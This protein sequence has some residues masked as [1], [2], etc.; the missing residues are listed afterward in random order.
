[1]NARGLGHKHAWRKRVNTSRRNL[2]ALAAG[3]T[4]ISTRTQAQRATQA[5]PQP[6]RANV[7]NES[8]GG[9]RERKNKFTVGLAS[10]QIEG[11]YPRF[12]AEL[13]KVLD[14]GDNLRVLPYLAYGAA[15]NVEDLLYLRGVDIAF[16]Q[17]DVL[18]YYRTQLKVPNLQDRIGYILRLYNT[19][20]HIL[21]ASD[22]RTMEDLR[23]RKVSFG[24]AGNSA[25]LTGPVVFQRLG[26]P[27]EQMLL[28]HSMGLDRLR[29]GEISAVVRVV[30]KP[31]DYFS[32]I[33]ANSGLHFLAIPGKKVFDDIYA[34]AEL[35]NADYP[36]LVAPG[37]TIDTISVPTELAVFNWAPKSE[38]YARVQRFVER[39]FER[40]DKLQVDPFHP[41]WREINLAAEVPGWKRSG[42]AQ[43]M[44][45][46]LTQTDAAGEKNFRAFL[47]E[48]PS[49]GDGDRDKLYSDFVAWRARQLAQPRR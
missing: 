45:A 29:K 2:L 35:T 6:T 43:Q 27:I 26:I 49:G 47:N 14:D 5:Q 3:A 19:E 40:W 46:K 16:T 34:L 25:A 41:K 7:R 21:A 38:R 4:F 9:A 44:L 11:L 36:T 39:M 23:G 17:S 8:E 20:V 32:K 18:E 33:P 37:D 1:M 15:S 48:R 28:D 12:A 10:G 22:I 31:V 30:G 42:V 24:P 13:Q